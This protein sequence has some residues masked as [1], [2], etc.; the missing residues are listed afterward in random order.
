MNSFVVS[1]VYV[2]FFRYLWNILPKT[3]SHN[4]YL[5]ATSNITIL[6]LFKS[7]NFKATP[8]MTQS[9]TRNFHKTVGEIGVYDA[10]TTTKAA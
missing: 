4:T 2:F 10:P 8:E 9:P 1:I 3:K 7:A 6:R 5:I